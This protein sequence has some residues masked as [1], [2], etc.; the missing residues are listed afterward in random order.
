[1]VFKIVIPFIC[2][3]FGGSMASFGNCVGYRINRGMNWVT[4]HSICPAC[5]ERLSFIELIP[6]FSCLLLKGRCRKCGAYFGFSDA[7]TEMIL[8]F[9]CVFVYDKCVIQS[10]SLLH[11]GLVGIIGAFILVIYQ[12]L[13][14]QNRVR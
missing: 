12:T 9:I 7:I 2:F 11:V 10:H 8:G 3:M 1:M 14:Y 6:V 4:G 5:G 13:V